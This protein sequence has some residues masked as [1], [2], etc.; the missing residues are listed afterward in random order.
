MGL[1]FLSSF[2]PY[3]RNLTI[4]WK[5]EF[6]LDTFCVTDLV[7]ILEHQTQ[8]FC[9]TFYVFLFIPCDADKDIGPYV[10]YSSNL[11]NQVD[12]SSSQK[13]WPVLQE[14]HIKE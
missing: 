4:F 5:R 8:L 6:P 10:F 2:K 3:L 1:S 12:S 11:V 9:T 13:T 14:S 7:Y